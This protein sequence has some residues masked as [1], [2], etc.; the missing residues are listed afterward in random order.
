MFLIQGCIYAF[1]DS[2]HDSLFWSVFGNFIVWNILFPFYDFSLPPNWINAIP[3][4]FLVFGRV[5][6]R[7]LWEK[8]NLSDKIQSRLLDLPHYWLY[9]CKFE[10]VHLSSNGSFVWN[11]DSCRYQFCLRVLEHMHWRVEV[12]WGWDMTSLGFYV[13]G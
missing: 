12:G 4:D 10:R 9:H 6:Y 11:P 5:E 1:D 7:D 13:D 2:H 3:H 8:L